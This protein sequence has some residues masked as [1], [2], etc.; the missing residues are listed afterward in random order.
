MK[1]II[2]VLGLTFL[3]S[4]FLIVGLP[5]LGN[6]DAG[7]GRIEIS[8][9]EYDAGTVSMAAGLV[10]KNYTVKNTGSGPLTIKSISTSCDC[11]SAVFKLNGK[12]SPTFSMAMGGLNFWSEK[13]QPGETG[14]LEVIFDPAFHGPHG[15][16][17][18]DRLAYVSSDDPQNGKAQVRLTANVI[19]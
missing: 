4:A 5:Y 3:I 12:I 16:G 7:Y 13:M 11:T 9:Q 2:I 10:Q 6:R 15:V 8:P 17:A 18:I 19:P 1:F 14:E